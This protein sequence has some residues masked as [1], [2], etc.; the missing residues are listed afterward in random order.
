VRTIH[1][2]TRFFTVS[3]NS[4]SSGTLRSLCSSDSDCPSP[5]VC[6]SAVYVPA[7][8]SSISG[9]AGGGGSKV[10]VF[11]GQSFVDGEIT[12]FNDVHALDLKTMEWRALECGGEVP[13]PRYLVHCTY[14]IKVQRNFFLLIFL[15]F[16]VSMCFINS[17]NLV[18][19]SRTLITQ[20]KNNN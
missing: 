15:I 10:Y 13:S 8:S 7:G 19:T 9:V 5:R 14:N 2:D 3:P 4:T 18:F 20:F 1:S 12:F 6:H 16:S 11:G 17:Y